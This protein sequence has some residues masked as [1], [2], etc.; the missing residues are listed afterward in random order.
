MSFRMFFV[1]KKKIDLCKLPRQYNQPERF[2]KK[3][4]EKTFYFSEIDY[5]DHCTSQMFYNYSNIL[6]IGHVVDGIV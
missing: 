6:L 1:F 2:N 4:V 3:F 5:R